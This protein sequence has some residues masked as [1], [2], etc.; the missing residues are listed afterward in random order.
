[1]NHHGARHARWKGLALARLQ[2]GLAILTQNTLKLLI[3][4]AGRVLVGLRHL[5]LTA[6]MF[7]DLDIRSVL[8]IVK[9][10]SSNGQCWGIGITGRFIRWSAETMTIVACQCGQQFRA[11][12][13]L[14]GKRVKCPSCGGTIAVPVAQTMPQPSG[15]T[16]RASTQSQIVA[17]QCGQRFK[18]PAHLAGQSVKCTSCGT[19]ISVPSSSTSGTPT[20]SDP[21]GLGS[22]DVFSDTRFPPAAQSRQTY[23]Q[24]SQLLPVRSGATVRESTGNGMGP[25]LESSVDSHWEFWS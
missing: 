25:S 1:M 14:A 17:C 4:D 12:P 16:S 8:Q 18:A 6:R 2:V 23:L 21:L 11:Q 3:Q 9:S 19:P 22:D 7:V 24:S 15:T 20:G 5:N 13:N 10:K